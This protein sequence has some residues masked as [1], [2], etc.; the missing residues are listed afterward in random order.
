MQI[1]SVCEGSCNLPANWRPTA[2]ESIAPT[3]VAQNTPRGK[4]DGFRFRAGR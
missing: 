3:Y 4:L 2:L 1:D